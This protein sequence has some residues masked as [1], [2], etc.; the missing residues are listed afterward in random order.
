MITSSLVH[1]DTRVCRA[2]VAVCRDPRTLIGPGLF[3]GQTSIVASLG[4]SLSD[5][6]KLAS[7]Q[8]GL[9][10][11]DRVLTLADPIESDAVGSR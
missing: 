11:D 6:V 10:A 4:S 9:P 2:I 3:T 5:S 8:L 1:R 7:M